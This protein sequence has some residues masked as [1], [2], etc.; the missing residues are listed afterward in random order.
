[1]ES[2]NIKNY[3][4]HDEMTRKKVR[5]RNYKK[6]ERSKASEDEKIRK[7]KRRLK[8]WRL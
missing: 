4:I 5:T 2:Q 6:D 8:T 7:Q 3:K 1:M